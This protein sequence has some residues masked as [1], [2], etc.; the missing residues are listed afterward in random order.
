[1]KRNQGR[2]AKEWQIS[3]EIGMGSLKRMVGVYVQKIDANPILGKVT[4]SSF[5][6]QAIQRDD[7]PEVLTENAIG[8]S[9]PARYFGAAKT[10][11]GQDSVNEV[12]FAFFQP[13]VALRLTH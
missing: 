8:I 10:C 7:F 1:M 6:R 2:R 9:P 11:L 3:L 12:S 5:L 13:N 4:L